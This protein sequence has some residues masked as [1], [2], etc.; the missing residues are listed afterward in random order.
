MPSGIAARNALLRVPLSD[1]LAARRNSPG[2]PIMR[3]A[4]GFGLLAL[5]CPAVV[6]AQT[7]AAPSPPAA[8]S[9][10]PTS[11]PATPEAKTPAHARGGDIT[12]D[13]YIE[14]AKRNAER[15]FERMDADHDGV[16]TADERRAYRAAH[17]RHREPQPQ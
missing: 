10:A 8:S 3:A 14:R 1:T 7:S 17:R 4:L 11:S 12:R 13:E 16:L 2:G 9:P 5:L 6:L 15:R